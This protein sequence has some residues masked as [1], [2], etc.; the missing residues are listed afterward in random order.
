[1]VQ[2]NQE[3]RG[4]EN[5]VSVKAEGSVI[6]KERSEG[7]AGVPDNIQVSGLAAGWMV[8]TFTVLDQRRRSSL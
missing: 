1:M 4:R 8:V 2:R 7:E 5:K 6:L 3:L